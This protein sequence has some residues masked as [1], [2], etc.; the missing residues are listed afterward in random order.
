MKKAIIYAHD[1][2][3]KLLITSSG[4]FQNLVIKKPFITDKQDQARSK[5]RSESMF[6]VIDLTK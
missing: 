4:D 1:N 3:K 5:D 2:G 6:K